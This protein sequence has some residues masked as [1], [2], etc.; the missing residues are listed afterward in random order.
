MIDENGVRRYLL[1]AAKHGYADRASERRWAKQPDHSTTIRHADGR[2]SLD[3]NFFGGEP[4]GGR[5]VVFFDGKPTWMM[6]YYGAVDASVPN[7][8]VVYSC[9][10]DALAGPDPE[11]PIRGPRLFEQGTM[12]YEASWDGSLARFSGRERIFD[13]GQEIYAASFAGGTVDA[14]RDEAGGEARSDK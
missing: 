4:Y 3:D 13:R 7:A 2:W 5:E 14:R 8:G 12:R 10:Q 11:M 1:K 9:L 6:V